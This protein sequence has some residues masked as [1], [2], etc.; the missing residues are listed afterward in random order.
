MARTK[1]E[2]VLL[3]SPDY[4]LDAM[5]DYPRKFIRHVF[6]TTGERLDVS[7]IASADDLNRNDVIFAAYTAGKIDI[8]V[9]PG[10][11][12]IDGAGFGNGPDPSDA[13]PEA[14]V[15]GGGAAEGDDATY[16]RADHVHAIAAGAVGTTELAASAVT[17]AKIAAAAQ[18]ALPAV[19]TFG[20]GAANAAATTFLAPGSGAGSTSVELQVPCTR[21]GVVRNMFVKGKTAPGALKTDVFTVNKNGTNTTLTASV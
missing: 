20:Q 17:L 14:V 7:S 2:L 11:S 12:D 4:V 10:A 9:T 18:A 16:S 15:A 5:I 8:V 21:A 19:L 3:T 1:I 13:D 6:R